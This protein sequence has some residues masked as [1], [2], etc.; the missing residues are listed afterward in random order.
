M[1]SS[2]GMIGSSAAVMIVEG[3]WS[4]LHVCLN[5]RDDIEG[6]HMACTF[7]LKVPSARRDEVR[8]V[9]AMINEPSA[10]P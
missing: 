10:P 2:T 7:D 6:L 8:R 3:T 9:T 1:K 5:W 4:D